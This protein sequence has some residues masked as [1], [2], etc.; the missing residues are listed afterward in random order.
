MLLTSDTTLT[1]DNA[2][3]E[4]HR[5]Q[6]PDS[7]NQED[8]TSSLPTRGVFC[9]STQCR[10]ELLSER[11]LHEQSGASMTWSPVIQPRS[12]L[13][14][15]DIDEDRPLSPL[16]TVTCPQ[17]SRSARELWQQNREADG[18][19]IFNQLRDALS[20]VKLRTRISNVS[21]PSINETEGIFIY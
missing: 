2:A 1:S 19:S 7:S 8:A 11:R 4:Y 17:L 20:D 5:T 9:T 16:E 12:S 15:A 14:L 6:P 3:P 13:G 18:E 21:L 10:R